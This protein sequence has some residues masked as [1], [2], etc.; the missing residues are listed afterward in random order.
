MLPLSERL[1]MG[2]IEQHAYR[3][4]RL[5]IRTA[6]DRGIPVCDEWRQSFKNFLRDM[7]PPSA[8][9]RLICTGD[10]FVGFRPDSC[11]WSKLT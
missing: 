6:Y 4:W 8:G 5:M 1:R 3:A 10:R 11:E 9:A 2:A 7:G